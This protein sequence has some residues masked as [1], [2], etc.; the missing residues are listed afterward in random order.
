MA[1]EQYETA[2]L[3]AMNLGA[4]AASRFQTGSAEGGFKATKDIETEQQE[5]PR[6]HL[7]T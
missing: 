5:H 1:Y 6:V 7:C 4:E 3:G 2:G